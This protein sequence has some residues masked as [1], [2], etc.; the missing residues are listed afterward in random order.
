MLTKNFQKNQMEKKELNKREYWFFK[1]IESQSENKISVL[2]YRDLQNITKY[3]S[4]DTIHRHLT[5]L[6]KLGII[7]RVQT[8]VYK[9]LR[10]PASTR[11]YV[12]KTEPPKPDKSYS[13]IVHGLSIYNKTNKNSSCNTDFHATNELNIS[14][15]SIFAGIP[16][17]LFQNMI[18]KFGLNM[19]IDRIRKLDRCYTKEKIRSSV[20]GLLWNALKWGHEWLFETK[21]ERD[22]LEREKTRLKL[23]SEIA[24]TKKIIADDNKIKEKNIAVEDKID[25]ILSDPDKFG[26]IAR[27]VREKFPAITD[28]DR[29]MGKFMI[30]AE[31]LNFS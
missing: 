8:S 6:I 5:A 22:M 28:F 16:K 24:E 31:A 29:G 15:D 10:T 17:R 3:K 1:I 26:K 12:R 7:E 19:V 13:K 23:D 4:R 14:D 18:R 9:I 2:T 21:K 11:K 27:A 20:M 30:R 25:A